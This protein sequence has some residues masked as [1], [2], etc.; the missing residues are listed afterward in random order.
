MPTRRAPAA[1]L[2][3]TRSLITGDVQ[4]SSTPQGDGDGDLGGDGGGEEEEEEEEPSAP[5]D[6]E[7]ERERVDSLFFR[8]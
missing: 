7:A 2:A 5:L 3:R 1:G 6:D 4:N 8:V